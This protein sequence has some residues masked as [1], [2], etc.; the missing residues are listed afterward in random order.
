MV[1]IVYVGRG[2]AHG[3]VALHDADEDAADDVD[4][5]DEQAGDRVALHELRR[6]VHGAEEVGLARDLVA[7]L[8]RLRLVDEP[9]AEVGVDG[10]L[11]AGHGVEREAR[12]HLGHAPRRP[13]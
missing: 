7:P 13:W 8:A 6:A 11:L 12:G 10:H 1:S 2:L 3:H 9:R 4:E 5:R